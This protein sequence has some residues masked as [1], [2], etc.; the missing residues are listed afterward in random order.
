MEHYRYN[1]AYATKTRVERVVDTVEF[2]PQDS[3]MPKE[4][5][6]D[7]TIKAAAELTYALQN[8]TSASPFHQFGD[9]TLRAL[10]KLGEIFSKSQPPTKEDKEQQTSQKKHTIARSS[11]EGGKYNIA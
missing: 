3:P 10:E 5:S 2:Y 11:S 9:E 8:P 6:T 7:M 1:K 4:S